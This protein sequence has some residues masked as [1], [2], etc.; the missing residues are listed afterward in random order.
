M[1][2]AQDHRAI[3]N[4]GPSHKENIFPALQGVAKSMQRSGKYHA[5]LWDDKSLLI[6][7]L[8][9]AHAEPASIIVESKEALSGIDPRNGELRRG[10][11][12]QSQDPCHSPHRPMD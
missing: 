8:W 9:H 4:Q 7:L 1:E 10:L 11:G 12:L 2:M 6:D 5:G 3:Y